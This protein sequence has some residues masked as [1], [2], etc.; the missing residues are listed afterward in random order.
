[1]C[2][3]LNS[4]KRCP[5]CNNIKQLN[6]FFKSSIRKNG[7][8]CYCKKCESKKGK[9]YRK[10]NPNKAKDYHKLWYKKN[11]D[12]KLKQTKEYKLKNKEKSKMWQRNWA[13]KQRKINPQYKL[14][15]CIRG[16]IRDTVK[17][18]FKSDHSIKLTGCTVEEYMNYIESLWENGMNWN[19]WGNKED[20]WHLDHIIPCELFDLTKESHQKIC[21][22]FKNTKPVWKSHNE[23]KSDKIFNKHARNMSPNE[24]LNHLKTL[25]FNV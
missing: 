17:R 1:M 14:K 25:G 6:E 10:D 15:C 7:I 2:Q 12:K 24:K 23:K 16:R 19:N 9:K 18:G 5:K 21:F 8:S 4:K 22:N 11:K 3:P 20:C 13:K